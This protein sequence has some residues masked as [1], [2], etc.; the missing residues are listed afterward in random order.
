[1]RG[2]PEIR[3]TGSVTTV[4]TGSVAITRNA[5]NSQESAG[6]TV[7]TLTIANEDG[8]VSGEPVEVI[9]RSLGG[10]GEVYAAS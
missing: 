2:G 8:W 6:V 3:I 7:A 10:T 9:I 1:M 4:A 5:G